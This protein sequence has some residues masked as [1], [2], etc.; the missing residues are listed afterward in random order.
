MDT[1]VLPVPGGPRKTTD[2]VAE[3]CAPEL[4]PLVGEHA[5][6]LQAVGREFGRHAASQGRGLRRRGIERRDMQFGRHVADGKVV[7]RRVRDPSHVPRQAT[8]AE[9]VEADEFARVA[10]HQTAHLR[11]QSSLKVRVARHSQPR[12]RGG[13]CAATGRAGAGR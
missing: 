4:A 13:G 5:L 3:G 1:W 7:G 6:E 2:R 10:D 9:A 11:W 12:A 8:Q